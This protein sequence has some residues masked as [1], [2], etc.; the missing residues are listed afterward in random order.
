MTAQVLAQQ[1]SFSNLFWKVF[2][3]LYLLT[4]SLM[5]LIYHKF[6]IFATSEIRSQSYPWLYAFFRGPE[7]LSGPCGQTWN[8]TPYRANGEQWLH[9]SLLEQG[10]LRLCTALPT[11]YVLTCI[12]H[13]N[14]I[15]TSVLENSWM[16]KWISCLLSTGWFTKSFIIHNFIVKYHNQWL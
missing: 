11:K 15:Q 1:V 14:W 3:Y 4:P 6:S 5:K 10:G 12:P 7:D 8:W 9:P 2:G 16:C 13:K